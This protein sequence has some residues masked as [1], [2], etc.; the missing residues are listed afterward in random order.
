MTLILRRGDLEPLVDMRATIEAVDAAMGDVA[1]GTAVQPAPALMR[2]PGSD[3]GFLPMAAASQRAGLA[4]VKLLADVPANA[5]HGLPTQRSSIVLVST[6]TG[7]VLAVLD[8]AVPTRIRTAAATAVATRHLARPGSTTLGLVGAGALAV[9]HVTAMLEVLPI[10][11]VHFW[12]RSRATAHGFQ[13]AIEQHGLKVRLLE[14]PHA[15]AQSVDVL[16]TLTPAVEPVV[17]GASFVPGLHVNAVGARPRPDHREV[18]TEAILRSRVFVDSLPTVRQKSGDIVIPVNEGALRFDDLE[19]ELGSVIAGLHPGR[20]SED[21]ITLF[22]S[23]GLGLQDLAIGRLLV[24]AA[25]ATGRGVRVD[26]RA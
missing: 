12:T 16:C 13:K 15:V 8:G 22:K 19:G 20:K 10:G 18:D 9:A 6:D 11:T 4:A 26:L 7:E 1:R 14:S 17:H 5:E 2:L 3:S 23:V 25:L 24:D 21:D